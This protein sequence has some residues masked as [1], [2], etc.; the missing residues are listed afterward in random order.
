MLIGEAVLP[1]NNLIDQW[2]EYL[3]DKGKLVFKEY[4]HNEPLAHNAQVPNQTNG[5]YS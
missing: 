4:P 2:I 5:N 1:I 3:Q